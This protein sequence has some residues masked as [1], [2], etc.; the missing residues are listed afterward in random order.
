MAQNVTIAGNQYPNVPSVLIPKT[1]GGGNA[2]FADPSVVTA[3][4]ADVASGKYFL[5]SSGVLTQGTASG[6]GG[7]SSWTKVAETSYQVSTTGTSSTTVATWATGHSELWTSDKIVYVRIRDTAGKRNGYFYGTDDF[8]LNSTLKNNP[9][10]SNTSSF[11]IRMTWAVNS[12]GNYVG[13]YG[14]TTTGYGVYAN[15]FY[16]TGNIKIN[17]RY[18]VNYSLTINGT[19][20][21]QAYLLDPPTGAPI[22]T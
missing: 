22:F 15:E 10:A 20:S 11:I 18:N 9:S 4:A 5:D 1:G 6:G 14:Y 17:S 13:R 2:I 7:S 16:S 19:Y 3:V 21:V 12:S 8:F